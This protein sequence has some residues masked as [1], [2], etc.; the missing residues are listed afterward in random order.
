M[1]VKQNKVITIGVGILVVI[2]IAYFIHMVMKKDKI[3]KRRRARAK[4]RKY[5][6]KRK[7]R[8]NRMGRSGMGCDGKRMLQRSYVMSPIMGL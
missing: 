4:A 6:V 5:A 7:A 8:M 3:V 2:G 1:N